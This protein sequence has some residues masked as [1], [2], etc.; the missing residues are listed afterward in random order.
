MADPQRGLPHVPDRWSLEAV[1]THIEGQHPLF[2][3]P[4]P[5][6]DQ[7]G[8]RGPIA[9]TA[10]STCSRRGGIGPRLRIQ[11]AIIGRH[12]FISSAGWK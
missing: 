9:A 10:A 2:D 7:R 3:V 11:A 6:D 8:F 1:V 5:V 4:A 12:S